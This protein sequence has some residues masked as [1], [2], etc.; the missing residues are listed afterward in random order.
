[1]R[2][3]AADEGAALVW[4]D[5]AAR[6]GI[7]SPGPF[8]LGI[9]L[10]VKVLQAELTA[11][12]GDSLARNLAGQA[13]RAT[14]CP[15]GSRFAP[16]DRFRAFDLAG[17]S[18]AVLPFVNQTS[19]RN[20]GEV[21]A[22]EITAQ[23]HAAGRLRVLEPGV[24]RAQL[25]DYRLP[26]EG[27]ISLDAARVLL[28]LADADLI[29]AGTVRDLDDP[30][31]GDAPHADFTMQWLDRHDEAV[32]WQSTSFHSGDDGVFF[33]GQGYVGTAAELACRMARSAVDLAVG[34]R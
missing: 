17:K 8:D 20:A 9:V 11:R 21:M 16:Q 10:D 6:A 29:V 1:M 31:G 23:L 25:A 4:I 19:R 12:L 24:L 14:G 27:G 28:S 22:L 33:F 26:M 13:P 32:V 7:D 15:G 34:P 18:V 30:P 5:Q 2:L 3:V